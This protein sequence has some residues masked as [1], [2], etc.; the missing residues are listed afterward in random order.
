MVFPGRSDERGTREKKGQRSDYEIRHGN[1]PAKEESEDMVGEMK[2]TNVWTEW[3]GA[4][5]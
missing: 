1:S 3:V 2:S 4:L 5:N